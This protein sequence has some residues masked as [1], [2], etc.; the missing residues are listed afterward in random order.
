MQKHENRTRQNKTDA[1][2]RYEVE[3]VILVSKRKNIRTFGQTSIHHRKNSSPVRQK[4]QGKS[5]LKL[6]IAP[7]RLYKDQISREKPNSNVSSA[8]Q[9]A[10]QSAS[11]SASKS[12]FKSAFKSLFKSASK[13]PSKS[14]PKSAT[15]DYASVSLFTFWPLKIYHCYLYCN[16]ST[17]LATPFF[18][19]NLTS[20]ATRFL[21]G[22]RCFPF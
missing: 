17:C 18:A 12:A 5:E 13:S 10:S 7:L 2:A 19:H 8:S 11:K 3:D 15:A 4:S 6:K 9:P 16:Y 22:R 20:S 14:A 1:A 21:A